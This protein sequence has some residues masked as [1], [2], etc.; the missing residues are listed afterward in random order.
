ML[1][2]LAYPHVLR[3]AAL[4]MALTML[5]SSSG[6]DSKV[7][8]AAVEAVPATEAASTAAT[9]NPPAPALAPTPAPASEASAPAVERG[10]L[11]K[12]FVYVDEVIPSALYDIRYY[13]EENF[14][15][16]QIDGYEAPL[17]ILTTEAANALKKV[18]EDLESQGYRLK[19]IDAYRPQ[20]AVN[21]F[22]AWS[23]DPKDT[24][25]KEIFYPD[26]DKKNLFKSGYLSSKSGHSRGSTVDVTMVF[27]RT[28]EEV[29]MGSRVDF[30]GPI[31]SHG[32]NLINKEQR[33]HRYILK[34]AMVK[35]NF[36]PYTKEWWHYTLKNEPFPNKY[37]NFDVK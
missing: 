20:K 8:A 19:I 21:H 14:I 26:V 24:L 18:N 22:V 35:Q 12:G 3:L 6:F 33:K 25:M 5:A 7:A 27:K 37:F 17:A 29:D 2:Y 15:G 1:T 11:P 30:L 31:S 4:G 16:T 23:K 10:T 34:T 36:K 28:G 13:S 32:T 9:V